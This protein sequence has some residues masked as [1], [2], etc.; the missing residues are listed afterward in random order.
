MAVGKRKKDVASQLELVRRDNTEGVFECYR[1][2]GKINSRVASA[3]YSTY[4]MGCIS[5][6]SKEETQATKRGW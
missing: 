1:F 3:Q 5:R 2:V 4:A 6:D